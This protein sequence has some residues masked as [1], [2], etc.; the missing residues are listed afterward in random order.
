LSFTATLIRFFAE[1]VKALPA[2][3]ETQRQSGYSWPRQP[4]VIIVEAVWEAPH[5]NSNQVS[6]NLAAAPHFNNS[7]LLSTAA[8]ASAAALLLMIC[9]VSLPSSAPP[10]PPEPAEQV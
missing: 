5:S 9:L 10:F 6:G 4:A 3:R 8:T 1:I 2:V 7:C